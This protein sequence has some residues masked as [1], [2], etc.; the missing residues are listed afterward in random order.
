MIKINEREKNAA[1]L[2]KWWNSIFEN[3]AMT[4]DVYTAWNI[5]VR[6]VCMYATQNRGKNRTP[7]FFRGFRGRRRKQKKNAQYFKNIMTTYPN[8]LLL[9]FFSSQQWLALVSLAVL[10]NIIFVVGRAVFWE[11]NRNVPALWFVLD[12]ICDTIYLIDILVHCHEGK[13]IW[14]WQTLFFSVNQSSII[15]IIILF[16][17][18]AQFGFFFVP[19]DLSAYT[20]SLAELALC[21]FIFQLNLMQWCETIQVH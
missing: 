4:Q 3:P 9:L 21:S 17:V 11:I 2:K 5:G 16:F 15:I 12:Y 13:F 10:Y 1:P 19:I 8:Q 20:L 14:I 6:I 7:A 18:M